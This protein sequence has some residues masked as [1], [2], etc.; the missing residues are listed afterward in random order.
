MS[1]KDVILSCFRCFLGY[2]HLWLFGAGGVNAESAC[3][4]DVC[5]RDT[6][7]KS[8]C[9]RSTC[10]GTSSAVKY[11]QIYLQLSQTSEVRLLCID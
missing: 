1:D 3:T 2:L 11:L 7:I 10:V 8:T 6:Y 4:R 5:I 9:V